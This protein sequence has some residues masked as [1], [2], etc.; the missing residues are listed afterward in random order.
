MLVWCSET[1]VAMSLLQLT[2]STNMFCFVVVLLLLDVSMVVQMGEM[3]RRLTACTIAIYV[4][5]E[6]RNCLN[7]FVTSLYCTGLKYVPI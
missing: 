1:S 2:A 7:G 6:Q 3:R 4:V 5:S